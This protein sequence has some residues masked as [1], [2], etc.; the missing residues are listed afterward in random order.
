[1]AYVLRFIDNCRMDKSDLKTGPLEVLEIQ[2]AS[3]TLLRNVQEVVFKNEFMNIISKDSKRLPIMRQLRLYIDDKG[4]LRSGGRIDNAAVSDTVKYPYLLPSKHSL[5]RLIIFDAHRRQAH[6]GLNGTITFI[7]QTFWIPKIRQQ[8]KTVLRSCIPCR[9]IISRPYNAPDPPPLPK[10]RLVEDPPFSVTGVDFTGALHVR[11]SDNRDT[12]AYLCLFTCATTR[13]VHIEIVLDLTEHSFILA[14]RRF[15][16][17]R[18][19]PQTMLSDNASTY[20]SAAAEITRLF[21]SKM[22]HGKLREHGTVWKFIPNRAL[23]YGG[24]WERLIGLTKNLLKKTLGRA[25]IDFDTLH[26]IVTEIECTL[27]DRPLTYISTDD[28]DPEP[29]TPSHLLYGRRLIG[30]YMR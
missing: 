29:L 26:T 24:W 25:F 22:V 28:K 11:N 20:K 18:S 8:V 12:K 7:Q 30:S 4:L 15:I 16:S 10:D 2:N 13:A 5:T 17:R 21:N 23:W 1:M 19:L 9:K 3:L 27:N 6:I 14:F